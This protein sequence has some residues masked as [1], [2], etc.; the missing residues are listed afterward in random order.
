[1]AC[2]RRGIG[3]IYLTF[4]HCAFSNAS[5]NCLREKM[6]SHTDCIYLTLFFPSGFSHRILFHCDNLLCVLICSDCCFRLTHIYQNLTFCLQSNQS[7]SKYTFTFHNWAVH[8]CGRYMSC[9]GCNVI[10]LKILF[11]CL[12][13]SCVWIYSDCCF[14]L[15]QRDG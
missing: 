5:S 14:R 1:M 13:V 7:F 8:V 15:T 6:H 11:H 10:I 4:L 9:L 2:L 3:C 12:S